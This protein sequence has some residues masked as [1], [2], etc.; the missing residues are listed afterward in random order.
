MRRR[1]VLPKTSV[2]RNII[3]QSQIKM[4]ILRRICEWNVEV[5]KDPKWRSRDSWEVLFALQL[6]LSY[7]SSLVRLPLSRRTNPFS[8]TA[9]QLMNKPKRHHQST[10]RSRQKIPYYIY[11]SRA[12]VGLTVS[13]LEGFW[14][15]G[16]I[17]WT[18]LWK[19]DNKPSICLGHSRECLSLLGELDNR[20]CNQPK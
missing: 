19:L 8:L 15:T 13:A 10:I 20:N 14:R 6:S 1:L 18:S 11:W 5:Y 16:N 7:Y 12:L 17:S 9:R 2:S 4:E 3:H